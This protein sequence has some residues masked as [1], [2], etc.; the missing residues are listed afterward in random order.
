MAY[1]LPWSLGFTNPVSDLILQPTTD[2]RIALSEA[3]LQETGY[4]T[5]S[6]ELIPV[7]YAILLP[8]TP[9]VLD[10]L[11][12]FIAVLFF[13]DMLLSFR[14]G[15]L[16]PGSGV[17]EFGEGK[18]A[19]KYLKSWFFIDL[20]ACIP[21]EALVA[22][23]SFAGDTKDLLILKMMRLPR[24]V[25]LSK[26]MKALDHMA[27]ANIFRILK[28]LVIY[29]TVAHW[30]ACAFFFQA[31]WQIETLKTSATNDFT[32]DPWIRQQCLTMADWKTQYSMSLHWAFTTMTTVG[33]GD[34]LPATN[35]DRL[36][37]ILVMLIG[38]L[39]QAIIFGNVS[40]LV[41]NLDAGSSRLQGFLDSLTEVIAHHKLPED[42]GARMLNSAEY[43]YNFNQ[44]LHT[45]MVL[46]KFNVALAV[47]IR[48]ELMREMISRMP[49]FRDNGNGFIRAIV[50]YF[51]PRIFTPGE[52][53]VREGEAGKEMYFIQDG[54]CK[55]VSGEDSS[56]EYARLGTGDFFGEIDV[57]LGTKRTATVVTVTHCTMYMLTRESLELVLQEFPG[58]VG[59]IKD[60]AL[61]RRNELNKMNVHSV[62]SAIKSASSGFNLM[63]LRDDDDDDDDDTL[64]AGR[65][66]VH[67]VRAGVG[68]VDAE[69]TVEGDR[70]G[71]QTSAPGS[72]TEGVPQPVQ[73]KML[74]MKARLRGQRDGSLDKPARPASL[75]N[76]Q[77]PASQA[78]SSSATPTSAKAKPSQRERKAA[79]RRLMVQSEEAFASMQGRMH[80]L[81][82]QQMDLKATLQQQ[83][84]QQSA[85][86]DQ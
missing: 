11:D 44:G 75:D 53:V 6:P 25:R 43:Q 71:S 15:Y 82:Q 63:R 1:A 32:G 10:N 5:L 70:T 28:L 54:R 7:K 77:R 45:D 16:P 21:L 41:Q 52:K 46:D 68:H 78:T 81:H 74:E 48:V 2:Q 51:E 34:I 73:I 8:T 24:L 84:Q 33:Y 37:T 65:T 13:V 4:T 38:G 12:T 72:R 19:K 76:H 17:I 69:A 36:C 39:L 14:T 56:I 20:I 27:S 31:R 57:I 64:A 9:E 62:V 35:M 79:I 22:A 18:V 80:A 61:A 49:I 29:V 42:L 23:A 67:T 3:C 83:K 55:V 86:K 30:V 50:G 40:V 47:D 66:P 59:P 58:L 60:Q 26:L 85:V